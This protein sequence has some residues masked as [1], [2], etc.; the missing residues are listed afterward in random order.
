MTADPTPFNNGEFQLQ[1]RPHETDGLRVLAPSLARALGF[2][3]AYDLLRS[4]PLEEKGSELVRTPGGDQQVGYLTEAGFYRALGQRQAARIA[5]ESIRASV[6][7]FQS[8]VYGEVLPTI[9]KTGGAYI[10]P[11]S[12][13]ELDLT[14]PDT[15]LDKLIEVARVAKAERAR[16]LELEAKIEA[17]APK[18]EAYEQFIEADGTYL[19]GTVAR[20]LGTS[21]N[22]LFAELR[23]RGVFIAKGAMK[24][25]PYQRYMHHFVVKATHFE[26]SD[27]SEGVSYTTRVKPSGVDFI[28]RRLNVRAVAS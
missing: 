13:A 22:K 16:R 26:R 23:D 21:Q 7:R 5:D 20:M 25:T 19:V 11:G 2:R 14:N 6:E 18:V 1:I 17:D 12:R 4:I 9:R 10:A 28:R 8:W 15:A 27:G 3:E 24:N